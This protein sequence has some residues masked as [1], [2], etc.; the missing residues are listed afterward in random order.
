MDRL[1]AS[2][3]PR[4]ILAGWNG[5][6]AGRDALSLAVELADLFGARLILGCVL[7]PGATPP[8]LSRHR[9]A[10][11][12]RFR[13]LVV[14]ARHELGDVDFSIREMLDDPAAGLHEL[15]LEEAADLVVLGST[16]HGALGRLIPGT[17]AERLLEDPPCA[18]ATAPHDYG[19]AEPHL[20]YGVA[21]VGYDGTP[22]SRAALA[23]AKVVA[24][25]T[26]GE[27]RIVSIAP[28]YVEADLSFGPLEPVRQEALLRLKRAVKS[29]E[30]DIPTSGVVMTGDAAAMLEE[31]AVEL[32]LL[33]IGSRGRGP[34]RD[35]LCGSV[36]ADVIRRAP[37]P[38]IVVPRE[39]SV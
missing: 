17:V 12:A 24:E 20:G 7:D 27:V 38:V 6:E 34:I 21:G 22:S 9:D 19:R 23:F 31:Q 37:C 39:P 2:N 25:A 36:S 18:I 1:D 33:V 26:G 14:T 13:D 29:L 35:R 11:A 28:D 32:D 4:R 10:W 30:E 3:A 15:V 5:S 8:E 16:H